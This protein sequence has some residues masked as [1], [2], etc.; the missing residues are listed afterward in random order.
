MLE[1]QPAR[2]GQRPTL[3]NAASHKPAGRPIGLLPAV[4]PTGLLPEITATKVYACMQAISE[5]CHYFRNDCTWSVRVC[6]QNFAI[7][8]RGV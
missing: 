1:L 8:R 3:L 6:V 7:V 5:K 2:L 4:P